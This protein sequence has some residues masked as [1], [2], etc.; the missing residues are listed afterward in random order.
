MDT[1]KRYFSN[2]KK[3]IFLFFLIYTISQMCRSDTMLK[4][5]S[6]L[7]CHNIIIIL[8]LCDINVW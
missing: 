7:S 8:I 3:Y 6:L 5:P 2:I 1:E 4:G